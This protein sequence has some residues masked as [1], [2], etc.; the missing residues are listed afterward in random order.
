[1]RRYE[2]W[3]AELPWQM[4]SHVQ[5]G[6]RPVLIVSND[7]ANRYSPAITVVPLT[8]QLH[9]HDLPTHVFLCG[10]GLRE[11]SIALCEQIIT[12][13]KSR[14]VH[15]IGCVV[16]PLDRMRIDRALAVQLDGYGGQVPIRQP[17]WCG[18][19]EAY[20]E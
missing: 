2:I 14:L 19:A 17:V 6:S 20:G 10:Q 8:S 15:K 9:K 3:F 16:N 4:G 1:M 12:L 11:K 18:K 13:D 7:T 5:Y